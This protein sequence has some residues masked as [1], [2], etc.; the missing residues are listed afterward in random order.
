MT[1]VKICGITNLEDALLSVKFG[2]DMLGFNFYDKSPRYVTAET[3]KQ[4]IDQLP[5]NIFKVGVFVNETAERIAEV[6]ELLGLNGI[7]LHGEESPEFVTKLKTMT[8]SEVIK[9]L[10]VSPD[11][12]PEDIQKYDA[13]AIL[14]DAYSEKGRG[15]TGETFSWDIASELGKT[16]PTLYLAGGLSPDNIADALLRVKPFAVDVCSGVESQAGLKDKVKLINF[17][18]IVR[19]SPKLKD[20]PLDLL[21]MLR[22]F[23]SRPKLY[24]PSKS[25]TQLCSFVCGYFSGVAEASSKKEDYRDFF[26]RFA[27]WLDLDHGSFD[28]S[29]FAF[30]SYTLKRTDDDEEE[31]FDLF[32]ALL[33]EFKLDQGIK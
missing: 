24:F 23:R 4:I 3:A 33:E 25:I 26:H 15:G 7:Q 27:R 13:D 32:F 20:G 11:F 12:R 5:Q 2:A 30:S 9:A 21:A 22:V 8:A 10:R 6:D 19:F 18:E 31:A 28:V 1:L 14:L 16:V 17:I 29:I